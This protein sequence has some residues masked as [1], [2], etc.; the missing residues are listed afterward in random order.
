M[1]G[2]PNGYDTSRIKGTMSLNSGPWKTKAP[3]SPSGPIMGPA[4]DEECE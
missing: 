2:N 4:E 1:A 3:Y